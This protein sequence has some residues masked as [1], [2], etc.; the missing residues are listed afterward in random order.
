[1]L[2]E[3]RSR[4]RRATPA[5]TAAA[6]EA[7]AVVIDVR[8]PDERV[9]TGEI[10]GSI[11]IARSVLEWRCD[12]AYPWHDARVARP[13]ARVILVCAH[14]FSSSLAADSLR[15]LGFTDVGDLIG[16]IAA[17]VA[18]GRPTVPMANSA[19]IGRT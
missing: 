17:W 13:E 12:P 8:G 10:P 6:L 5:E 11:P 19:N 18:E 15:Q 4:I 3:A 9:A 14:G 2:T 7:G 16:G 1:M